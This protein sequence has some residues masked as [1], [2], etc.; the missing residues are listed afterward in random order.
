MP[1]L[2]SDL[3]KDLEKAVIRARD[4]AEAGAV[5]ALAVL[6]VSASEA[7]TGLGPGQRSLRV[8]LRAQARALG[9]EVPQ[10]GYDELREE[11]AYGAWHRML[12]ARFLA[13]NGLLVHPETRS[14][15]SMADVEELA[16][17]GVESDPWVVA[18]R[19]AAAMLP[20]IFGTTDPS[21]RACARSATRNDR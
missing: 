6:G 15:V 10:L 4:T 12:F 1:P 5:N 2:P 19:Y 11:I 20:G 16:R 13:E 3:R 8:A 7:P 18:A 21:A 9:R 14:P 17:G